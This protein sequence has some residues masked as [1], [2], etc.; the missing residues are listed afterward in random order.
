MNT[1]KNTLL[2]LLLVPIAAFAG[3]ADDPI[4]TKLMVDRL[5]VQAGDGPDP[6]VLEAD[7][8]IGKDLNKLWFKTDIEQVDGVVEEQ[9]LQMLY[10]RAIDAYWDLQIG[11]RRDLKPQPK[12]DWW[13]LGLHGTAP[14]FIESDMA[15]FFG[16]NDQTELRLQ[17]EYELMF[18]QRLVLSPEVEA[19]LF[20]K[21]DPAEGIG[22]GLSSLNLGLR[23]GYEIRR[24]FAPYIGVNWQRAMGETADLITQAGGSLE[25]TRYVAGIRFWF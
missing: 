11:A 20:S 1:L 3:G 23:L 10:S 7:L 8:W 18:T 21:N 24:E 12:S 4:L 15:L 13:V 22:S 9:E 14:Y 6:I 17:A 2:A 16:E 25:D 5:E 19:K